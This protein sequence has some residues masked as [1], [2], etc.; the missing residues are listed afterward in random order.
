MLAV[1]ISS[2]LSAQHGYILS[3]FLMLIEGKEVLMNHLN[4]RNEAAL[5]LICDA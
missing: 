3:R 1:M 2:G 5:C 4:E